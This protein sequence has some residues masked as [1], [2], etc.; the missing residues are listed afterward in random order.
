MCKSCLV[1]FIQ[2]LDPYQFSHTVL[3]SQSGKGEDEMKSNATDD[4][5]DEVGLY[6]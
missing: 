6:A 1:P 2:K 4:V 5:F 3:F